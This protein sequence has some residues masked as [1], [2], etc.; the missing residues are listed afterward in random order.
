MARSQSF[1]ISFAQHPTNGAV[2]KATLKNAGSNL[3]IQLH[4]ERFLR[5]ETKVCY[6]VG[7]NGTLEIFEK[8]FNI[9]LDGTLG[10]NDG[11]FAT[12][13][14]GAKEN[15]EIASV[16]MIIPSNLWIYGRSVGGE[17]MYQFDSIGY[18]GTAILAIEHVQAFSN[19]HCIH[20]PSQ[21]PTSKL[22]TISA[23][24]FKLRW[25]GLSPP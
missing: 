2:R 4:Q 19:L 1:R 24:N 22:I 15:A 20:H 14:T 8:E 16:G 3:R 21:T 9:S 6:A 10:D 25:A 23:A 7:R 13:E 17:G 11:I 18:V 12:V 5:F